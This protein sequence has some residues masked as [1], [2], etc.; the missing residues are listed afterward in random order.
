MVISYFYYSFFTLLF[1]I[2]FTNK[3]KHRVS[4]LPNI[5][6]KLNYFTTPRSSPS[7]SLSYFVSREIKLSDSLQKRG[8]E[9][10]LLSDPHHS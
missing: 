3:M 4:S 5:L 7:L 2:G 6:F 8:G 1:A 10:L 9:Q